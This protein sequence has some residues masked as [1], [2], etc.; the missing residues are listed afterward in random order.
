MQV[1]GR[2]CQEYDDSDPKPEFIYIDVIGLGA[3]VVDRLTELGLP[4]VGINIA[5]TPSASE[6]YSRLRDELWYKGLEWFQKR[7]C[8]IERVPYADALIAEISL[9]KS[10]PPTSTGKSLV[11][12]RCETKRRIKF[13]PDLADSLMLTFA[14][15]WGK[16]DKPIRYPKLRIV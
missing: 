14:H 10:M 5:E 7:D 1:C 8:K 2:V 4:V 12:P 6:K 11:E 9:V 16:M 15:Y 13:S 3:G